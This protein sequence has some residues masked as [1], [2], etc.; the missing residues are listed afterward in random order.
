MGGLAVKGNRSTFWTISGA[1]LMEVG[2]RAN[3]GRSRRSIKSTPPVG[4]LISSAKV[5]LATIVVGGS[6]TIL[7]ILPCAR[8][9]LARA[10]VQVLRRAARRAHPP[11]TFT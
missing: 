10:L 7:A 8:I 11:S 9:P 5:R 3:L 2:H 1:V 6:T 4:G